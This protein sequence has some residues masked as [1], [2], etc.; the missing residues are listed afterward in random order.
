MQT[1]VTKIGIL[2][3]LNKEHW[4]VFQEIGFDGEFGFLLP[5]QIVQIDFHAE[6]EGQIINS[7]KNQFI[8]D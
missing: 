7:I 1:C 4:L 5:G 2:N 3:F 6:L 8:S